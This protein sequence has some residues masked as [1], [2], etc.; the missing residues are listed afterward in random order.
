M[1]SATLLTLGG[2][3]GLVSAHKGCGGPGHEVVRRNPGGPVVTLE[4]ARGGRKRANSNP[5]DGYTYPPTQNLTSSYPNPYNI[6][7]LLPSDTAA[8]TLFS[9]IDAHVRSALPTTYPKGNPD[10]SHPGL[11]YDG[12]A[13]PDCW[14]TYTQC[15]TPKNATGLQRDITTVPEPGSY[16]LTYDDGPN[17]G[18]AP[19]Y[20][21]MEQND[22]RATLFYIGGN[23][24]NWPLQAISGHEGGHEI[25]VHTWSHHYM[26]ALSNEQVFAELYYTQRI[27][28]DVLGVT[29]LCWRPPYGDIDNRVRMIAAGLNLT[30]VVWSEDSSDWSLDSGTPQSKID[31]NY[32]GF[33]DKQKSGQY[34]N[35]GPVVLSHELSA[36][37]IN[38]ALKFLPSLK[39]A[40]THLVPIATAYN[41]SHPYAEEDIFYPSF[42]EY[43]AGEEDTVTSSLSS[44]T[45]TSTS[46]SSSTSSASTTSSS[47]SASSTSSAALSSSSAA[48]P[49][50][51]SEGTSNH[52]AQPISAGWRVEPRLGLSL[53]LAIICGAAI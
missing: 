16:G 33:I 35:F 6:A 39:A 51:P 45:S 2:L 1:R 15:T 4:E 5:C 27:I 18:N 38:E 42:A 52:N 40:F 31:A 44:I 21:W 10:G 41:I 53:A 23:V 11:V 9:S 22:V 49:A 12:G 32:Q 50:S 46:A 17:C 24:L 29:P 28:K 34:A 48:A 3:A 25:C 26:T 20:D 19:L 37:T 14:W 8:R 13:D 7:T 43:V 36:A 47:V 30:T